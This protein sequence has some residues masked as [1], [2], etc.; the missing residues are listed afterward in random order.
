MRTV[1]VA[2][3]MTVESDLTASD[4]TMCWNIFR[5]QEIFEKS[6]K[7]IADVSY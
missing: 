7:C 1:L 3:I 5:T 4:E 6:N 2:R